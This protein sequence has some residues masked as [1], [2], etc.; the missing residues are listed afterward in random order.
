M[1]DYAG[2]KVQLSQKGL[3]YGADLVVDLLMEQLNQKTLN[4]ITGK[5][6]S[7]KYEV[8]NIKVIHLI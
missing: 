8:T 5:K 2:I 6:G 3:D 1:E 7:L 4:D